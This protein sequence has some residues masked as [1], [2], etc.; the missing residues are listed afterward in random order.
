MPQCA[1][2]SSDEISFISLKK[3]EYI[4]SYGAPTSYVGKE[5][6]GDYS[7]NISFFLFDD[8]SLC[9]AKMDI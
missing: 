8:F 6:S 7:E 1:L 5:I 3:F 2:N 4:I 9:L